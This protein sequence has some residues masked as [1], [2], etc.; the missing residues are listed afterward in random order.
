MNKPVVQ[1]KFYLSRNGYLYNAAPRYVM[2]RGKRGE[3][4]QVQLGW[5]PS[6]IPVARLIGYE[7]GF[8]SKLTEELIQRPDIIMEQSD[9]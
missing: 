9:G 8:R 5:R 1:P 7:A 2:R 6:G 3:R 4:E